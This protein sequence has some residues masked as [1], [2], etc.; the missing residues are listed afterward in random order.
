MKF[1]PF[2]RHRRA[3]IAL[4]FLSL[5]VILFVG[6]G[7]CLG[8]FS[9][10]DITLSEAGPWRIVGIDRYGPL[11]KA[12][13]VREDEVLP[14][15]SEQGLLDA[16]GTP[17]ALADNRFERIP[18][19]ERHSIVGYLLKDDADVT[20]VQLPL[21]LI[22]LPRQQSIIAILNAH[23]SVAA[24]KAYRTINDTWVETLEEKELALSSQSLE[25]EEAE[26]LVRIVVPVEPIAR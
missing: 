8:L 21:K 18:L 6:G 5:V 17:C 10:V 20:D 25:I 22:E 3:V 14:L 9:T 19:K 12:M 16:I 13:V 2:N 24:F 1:I 23:R 26:N 15:L 7:A 4:V 11:H